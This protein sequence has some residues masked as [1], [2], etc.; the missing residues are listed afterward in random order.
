MLSIAIP[1]YNKFASIDTTVLSCINACTS[2]GINHEIV[3]ANNASK[4]AS[5]QEI[6]RLLSKYPSVRTIHLPQTISGPD[7]WLFALNCCQGK[8][9]K[10]QLADDE[11]PAFDLLHFLAPLDSDLVDYVIGDTEVVFKAEDFST[12]YYSLVNSFRARLRADLTDSQKMNLLINEGQIIDSHNPF[13][14]V[15]AL[16][17][18][19]K[20]LATLNHDIASFRP[21]F[22][23]AP[24][25]D[26]YLNL[27]A[28]HRGAYVNQVVAS[29]CYYKNSPCVRRVNEAGYDHE[30][31][32]MHEILQPFYFISSSKFEP[33]TRHLNR[34]Q[35]EQ[36]LARINQITKET[37]KIE[38]PS[39]SQPIDHMITRT[40]NRNLAQLRTAKALVLA[41]LKSKIMHWMP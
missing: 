26:L 30:G 29:F 41:H 23:I 17:F 40:I 38:G 6:D 4:D 5:P 9:V 22:T 25:I 14:D 8:Y 36:F 15:N 2:S 16:I 12:N 10:I 18:H 20:C 3:V 19:R 31:L 34:D 28:H 39:P 13:G 35:K 27:F 7:N 21:S 24:D 1:L 37:L 32:R 33:L 11:M